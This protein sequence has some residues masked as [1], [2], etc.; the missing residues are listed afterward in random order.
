MQLKRLPYPI[1]TKKLSHNYDEFI[2][3]TSICSF[4]WVDLHKL[5]R[6]WKCFKQNFIYRYGFHIIRKIRFP[7]C[8]IVKIMGLVAVA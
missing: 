5:F 2:P 8:A 1:F 7:V 3:N 4:M 6:Q